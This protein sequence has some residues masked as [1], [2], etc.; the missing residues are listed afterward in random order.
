MAELK[1]SDE[2]ATRVRP[3]VEEVGR[4]GQNHLDRSGKEITAE[5]RLLAAD[6]FDEVAKEYDAHTNLV[7]RMDLIRQFVS[8]Y[9][10]SLKG[11]FLVIDNYGLQ[12]QF[13]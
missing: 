6:L 4:D 10:R 3:Q 7:G 12:S 13:A 8:G 9:S 11:V 5:L 2:R 1:G